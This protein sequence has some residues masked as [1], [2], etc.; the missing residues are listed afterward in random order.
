MGEVTFLYEN[1]TRKSIILRNTM[2]FCYT[3]RSVPYFVIIAEASSRSKWEYRQ[4]PIASLYKERK[5]E[6]EVS[7]K[8]LHAELWESH[9]IEGGQIVRVRGDGG[10]TE[11]KFS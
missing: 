2:I 5:S 3:H 11:N 9:G 1:F 4:Q 8:S 10:H 6:L 7:I